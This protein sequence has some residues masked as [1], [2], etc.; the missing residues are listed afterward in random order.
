M[1][2]ALGAIIASSAGCK[3]PPRS[4]YAPLTGPTA[5]R[6]AENV[7]KV[8]PAVGRAV[9][10]QELQQIA[11]LYIEYWTTNSGGPSKIE[12]LGLD[13]PDGRQI[14]KLVMNGDLVIVWHVSGNNTN[15]QVLAYEKAAPAQGGL[16]ANRDGSVNSVTAE[17]FK[18]YQKAFPPQK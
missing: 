4:A 6:P 5:A 3:P 9:N 18:E 10:R 14:L 11:L 17:E 12:D 15:C 8:I 7:G 1:L 16:V 13:Q 2:F